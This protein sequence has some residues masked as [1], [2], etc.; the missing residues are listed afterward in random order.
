[1]REHVWFD[2]A[3][4]TAG[5][6]GETLPAVPPDSEGTDE[7]AQQGADDADQGARDAGQAVP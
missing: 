6:G 7:V 1:V 5:S 3:E 2:P 4:D